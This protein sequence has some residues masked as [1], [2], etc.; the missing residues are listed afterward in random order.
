MELQRGRSHCS[1]EPAEEPGVRRR[2]LSRTG[3]HAHRGSPH[4]AGGRPARLRRSPRSKHGERETRRSVLPAQLPWNGNGT[5]RSHPGC[6][7]VY[8]DRL[9]C[10]EE[11][12]AHL[13]PRL[14]RRL[15]TLLRG[16]GERRVVVATHSAHM[17]DASETVVSVRLE[18]G[19]SSITEVGDHRLFDELR[20]LGYR[21]S[22]LLQAN[23][24]VWVEGPSDRIY[25]LRWLHAL[26]PDLVEG[27]DFSVAFYGGALLSRLSGAIEGPVDPSL[28][29][30]WRINRRMWV[31]MDSDLGEG[32]LKPAVVRLQSEIGEAGSG[33][34]WITAG[35]TIEN[36]I[37]AGVLFEAVREV[38]PS[39]VEIDG[40]AT[41]VDPLKRLRHD[42]G[43]YLTRVDKVGVALAVTT[44][45]PNLNVLDLAERLDE[46]VTFIREHPVTQV[47]EV[48]TDPEGEP[49]IPVGE[50]ASPT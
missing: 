35:Y 7:N 27:I 33:G 45:D 18:D 41:D 22:D 37:D 6:A 40:A 39:V 5:R 50:D 28:V 23:C 8:P 4:V 1:T 9:L 26:G 49:V 2:P 14:Q 43:N 47:P 17:I 3:T 20:A 24:L 36:Y 34:T 29:D 38:H 46:L 12:D 15:V 31:V 11:P 21:A 25:L 19:R 42:D 30:L 32:V 10:L 44:V 13:H 16:T 48:P